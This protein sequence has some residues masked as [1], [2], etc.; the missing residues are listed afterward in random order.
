MT[1][2][3]LIEKL[4]DAELDKKIAVMREKKI[5]GEKKIQTLEEL[6]K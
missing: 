3:D 5:A 2:R 4:S 6:L 1:I